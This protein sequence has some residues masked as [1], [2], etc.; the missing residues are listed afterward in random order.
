MKSGELFIIFLSNFKERM[1]AGERK[2]GRGQVVG[3]RDGRT[4]RENVSESLS[5]FDCLNRD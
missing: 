3:G 5:S 1:V 2:R 4:V